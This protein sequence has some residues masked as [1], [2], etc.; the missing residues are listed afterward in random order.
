[1]YRNAVG[2]LNW[3]AGILRLDIS[4][5]MCEASTKFKNAA[6]KDVLYVNMIIKN[7]ESTNYGITFPQLS[8]E[9]L[10]LQLLT[11]A[12]SNNLPNG[13]SQAGQVLFLTDD[14]SNTCPLYWDSSK[15]KR[16]VRSTI[17]AETL[18]LTDECD[19]S[20]YINRSLELLLEHGKRREVIA[21]TDNQ[22][23]YNAGHNKK[24]T[25]E[26]RLLVE[27]AAIREMVERN[28]INIS[29]IKK[30]KQLGDILTK[31]GAS[32]KIL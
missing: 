32:F 26:K 6:M 20:I 27:T 7:A 22:S 12:S 18:Y 5:P 17:A 16:V 24:Q 8:M 15:I 1:M 30:E 28:E 2:Q 25:L 31:S 11:D 9:D 21:Y 3:V 10:K 23:L 13:G 19:V 4:F 29:W 14:K